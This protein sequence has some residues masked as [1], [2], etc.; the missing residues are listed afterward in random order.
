MTDMIW[1]LKEFLSKKNCKKHKRDIIQTR[2]N[3]NT[4]KEYTKIYKIV[5]KGSSIYEL[6]FLY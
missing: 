3:T 2:Q 5:K 4:T 1:Y 6:P